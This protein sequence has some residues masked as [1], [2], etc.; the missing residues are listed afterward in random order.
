[1]PKYGKMPRLD[2]HCKVR[3]LG[4]PP[5]ILVANKL[6]PFD[7]KQFSSTGWT[8]TKKT[9]TRSHPLFV[10]IIQHLQLTFS[11]SYDHSIYLA[12][13]SVLTILSHNLTP[14]FI[15]PA[16]KS[17]IFH[18]IIHAFF[19]SFYQASAKRQPRMDVIDIMVVTKTRNL[20]LKNIAYA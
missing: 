2:Y 6:M 14:S 3:L 7:S 8:G 9:Y 15:W 10:A 19:Q 5:H 4:Y 13:S 20:P 1:M 12:Y 18:F 11:I 17:Y 16:S